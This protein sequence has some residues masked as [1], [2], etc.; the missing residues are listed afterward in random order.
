MPES[1]KVSV[2]KAHQDLKGRFMSIKTFEFEN[3]C[4]ILEMIAKF[5]PT[6]ITRKPNND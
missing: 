5:A 4:H 6:V 1:R 3:T 2:M